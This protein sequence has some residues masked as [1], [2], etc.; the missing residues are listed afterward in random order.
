MDDD[1]KKL[2]RRLST[3]ATELMEDAHEAAIVSIAAAGPDAP[4][5]LAVLGSHSVLKAA[6]V[7]IRFFNDQFEPN[8]CASHAA[9]HEPFLLVELFEIWIDVDQDD[10]R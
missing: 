6:T 9:I 4:H 8:R 2:L 10:S 3:L 5:L 7:F 1:R